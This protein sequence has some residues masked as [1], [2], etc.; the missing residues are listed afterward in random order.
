MGEG[1]IFCLSLEVF[2]EGVGGIF[3][4]YFIFSFS[5]GF[6]SRGCFGVVEGLWFSILFLFFFSIT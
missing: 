1:V 6:F 5:E 2:F 3:L 4:F